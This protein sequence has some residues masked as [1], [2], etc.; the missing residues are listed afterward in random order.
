MNFGIKL[1]LHQI[2]NIKNS[3][4]YNLEILRE[5]IASAKNSKK[6]FKNGAALIDDTLYN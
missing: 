1:F 2:I 3:R 4:L 6:F 5:S